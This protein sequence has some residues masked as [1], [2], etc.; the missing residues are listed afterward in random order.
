LSNQKI[1]NALD[2]NKVA[3]GLSGGVYSTAAAYL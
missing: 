1:H 3:V 2:K